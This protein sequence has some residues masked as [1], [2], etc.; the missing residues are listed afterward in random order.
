MAIFSDW[1]IPNWLD[2]VLNVLHWSYATS[3]L[4]LLAETG[5][6]R[7][8]YFGLLGK[9]FILICFLLDGL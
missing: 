7:F 3:S 4:Q 6:S 9:D 1:K 8:C 5:F 2:I